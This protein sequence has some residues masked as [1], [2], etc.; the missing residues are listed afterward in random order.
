MLRAPRID[1]VAV[2]EA[3]RLFGL[4]RQYFCRLERDFMAC[5]YVAL[6]G[7]RRAVARPSGFIKRSSTSCFNGR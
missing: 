5:G 1:E 4:S 7:A 6:I 3:F 2:T